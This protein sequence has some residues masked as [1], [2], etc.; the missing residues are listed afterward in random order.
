MQVFGNQSRGKIG[1]CKIA[2]ICDITFM[3]RMSQIPPENWAEMT[4]AVRVFVESL[5]IQIPDMRA[6]ID[7]LKA[8]VK[9]LV[10][11]NSSMPP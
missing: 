2:V 1:L 10:P 7:D 9:R 4:P 6:Q 11:Q 5:L 3:T 8:P